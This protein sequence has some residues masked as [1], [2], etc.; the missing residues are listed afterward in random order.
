M[1]CN[2]DGG[3]ACVTKEEARVCDWNTMAKSAFDVPLAEAPM[4]TPLLIAQAQMH[5]TLDGGPVAAAEVGD[6][7]SFQVGKFPLPPNPKQA[8]GDL[9]VP[10]ALV[11]SSALYYM[12]LAFKEGARKYGPYN[13]REK[14]VESMTYVNAT[15]RH[16]YAWIDG[17]EI[18]PE[19]GKPHLGLAMASLA[20]IVDSKETGSLIDTRPKPGRIGELLRSAM[21]PPKEG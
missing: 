15:L 4:N 11:P 14:A 12:G 13:W 6:A 7:G 3:C 20:I 2:R 16:L 21:E 1:N 8:Y 18:D 9:K 17:E 10:L 5:Q 19:S